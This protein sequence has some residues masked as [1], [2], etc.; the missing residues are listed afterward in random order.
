MIY[1]MSSKFSKVLIKLAGQEEPIR[2][3]VDTSNKHDVDNWLMGRRPLTVLVS[4][5]TSNF[6]G[7]NVHDVQCKLGPNLGLNAQ[8]MFV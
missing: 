3:T 6:S 2:A 7:V 5:P 8:I 1:A 4:D